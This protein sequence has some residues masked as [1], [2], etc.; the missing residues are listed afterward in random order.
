MP[1]GRHNSSAAI[2]DINASLSSEPAHS[3]NSFRINPDTTLEIRSQYGKNISSH[4]VANI[5]GHWRSPTVPFKWHVRFYLCNQ[6]L[7]T[8]LE[9][10]RQR[11][12]K[13]KGW[14]HKLAKPLIVLMTLSGSTAGYRKQPNEPWLWA[15][16]QIAPQSELPGPLSCWKY[17]YPSRRLFPQDSFCT[18]SQS[19]CCT[20]QLPTSADYCW[21]WQLQS[22]CFQF[23]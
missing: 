12:R 15:I 8:G 22:S 16:S 2:N 13:Q 21:S 6:R 5:S 20:S 10:A 7:V 4:T 11:L 17:G 23:M 1:I 9:Q 3:V 18:Q 14:L 19:S